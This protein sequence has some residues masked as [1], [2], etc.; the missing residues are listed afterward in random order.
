M[1][2]YLL[3][4]RN[5]TPRAFQGPYLKGLYFENFYFENFYS[6]IFS[7]FFSFENYYLF[8]KFISF[9]NIYFLSLV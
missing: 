5:E 6:K 4:K 8:E 3:H 2:M 9:E 7:N 1:F